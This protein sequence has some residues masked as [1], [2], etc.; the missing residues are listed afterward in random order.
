VTEQF[1]ALSYAVRGK[2]IAKYLGQ[3]AIVLAALTTAPLICSIIFG[4]LFL[5]WRYLLVIPVL[6]TVGMMARFPAPERIQTNEAL[7]IVALTFLSAP[8]LMSFPIMGSGLSFI[9]ALFEAV[10]GVTTT[11]LS[12]LGTIEDKSKTLMF[13]RAW[14][15]WYGGLGIV[16]FSVALLIKHPIAARQLVQPAGGNNEG[17]ATTTRIHARRMLAVYAILTITGVII[18][19]LSGVDIFNSITHG[20]AAVSTGGFSSF[21]NGLAEFDGPSSYL[22]ILVSL[23]GAVALPLYYR[24]YHSGLREL[25]IDV[26]LRSLL[27]AVILTCLILWLLF[28]ATNGMSGAEAAR[29]AL[30]MGISAQSTTGF[31]SLDVAQLSPDAKL[32]MMFSMAIGGTVG[33]TAGGLKIL[34]LLILIRLVQLLIQRTAM[35][36]HAVAEPQLGGRKLGDDEIIRALLLIVLFV[37]VILLSWWPFVLQ[38]YDPLNAL[39]EVVSA[40]GTVGLSTGITSADLPTHLKLILCFDMWFGRLEILVFLVVLYPWTWI[41]KR[42]ATP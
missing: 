22:L 38:G 34:R 26:E 33:S 8:L 20:L 9:D 37:L 36:T 3:L 40:I 11:G 16:V 30:L 21:N 7:C 12:T 39:F 1:E 25:L 18:L 35:P 29:H 17:I 6:L 14:S 13:S 23:S 19:A 2:V 27:A 15:Q 24:C 4:E 10:S 32:A 41:G 5:S 31:S 28:Y 42:T